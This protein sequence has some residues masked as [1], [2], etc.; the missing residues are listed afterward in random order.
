MFS[1]GIGLL[2]QGT[3]TIG[4]KINVG[5][6]TSS[7]TD[8]YKNYTLPNLLSLKLNVFKVLNQLIYGTKRYFE[9]FPIISNVQNLNNFKG[10]FPKLC[11][12]DDLELGFGDNNQIE[13]FNN[14]VP[15]NTHS[16]SLHHPTYQTTSKTDLAYNQAGQVPIFDDFYEAHNHYQYNIHREMTPTDISLNNNM[17]HA[18]SSLHQHPQ[19]LYSGNFEFEMAKAGLQYPQQ[20]PAPSQPQ[21]T[22]RLP[23]FP[24]SSFDMDLPYFDDFAP[25]QRSV[26]KVTRQE[27]GSPSGQSTYMSSTCSIS[28]V[29][30]YVNPLDDELVIKKPT[31]TNKRKRK[32]EDEQARPK[33][34]YTKKSDKLIQMQLEKVRSNSSSSSNS[35]DDNEPTIIT[36]TTTTNNTIVC[37]KTI[38]TKD[39]TT[40]DNIFECPHCDATFKVKGYL[41]RHLKKHSSSKAFMCPFYQEDGNIG[42]K[43]HPTGGF[44]R[45]DTFKTHLKALHFIYPPG[46]K[47]SERNQHSGRCAGC[48]QYFENNALW[49]ERHIEMQKCEG[50]VS[51][52]LQG[53]G[54]KTEDD[55]LHCHASHYV[56]EEIVD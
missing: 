20:K 23:Y 43:C 19:L 35:Y 32:Q 8:Y 30:S 55:G 10:F 50:T 53:L 21:P 17:L 47:S 29:E 56:K 6:A 41:T 34:K 42:T 25:V 51:H 24:D 46:T 16:N 4:G 48:F 14:S 18:P 7:P 33:R 45:R 44:S 3:T 15:H 40:I 22:T 13:F 38:A 1:L 26:A 54:H 52:K 36:T 2:T 28:S 49:L 31:E 37:K 12:A 11:A 5:I 9:L 27:S 39:G